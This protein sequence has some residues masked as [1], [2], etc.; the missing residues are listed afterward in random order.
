M[1]K[2]ESPAETAFDLGS[3]HEPS[4]YAKVVFDLYFSN[5]Y[6]LFRMEAVSWQAHLMILIQMILNRQF[7]LFDDLRVRE[8]PMKKWVSN[9]I[10]S[11]C[12]EWCIYIADCSQSRFRACLPHLPGILSLGFSDILTF[13]SAYINEGDWATVSSTTNSWRN[14]YEW[15]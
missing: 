10:V 7:D 5:I 13:N 8:I 4:S 9:I 15:G 2:S 11:V 12:V 6:F 3:Y 14:H 1:A